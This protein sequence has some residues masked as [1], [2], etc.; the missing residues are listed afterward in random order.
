LGDIQS[1]IA[2][3]GDHGFET[4]SLQRRALSCGILRLLG[5]EAVVMQRSSATSCEGTGA[6][7]GA[8]RANDI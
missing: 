2:A 1:D 8:R 6:R 5:R 4:R 3:R 7:E